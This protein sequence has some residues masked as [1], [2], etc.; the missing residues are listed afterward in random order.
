MDI[1]ALIFDVNGTLIDI[2]TDEGMEQIYRSIGHF[3]AYQGIFMRRWEVRDL[4]FQI[5]KQ[6]LEMSQEIYPEFD[7]VAV[8]RE[9]LIQTG[10]AYT[11]SLPPEKFEQLPLFLAELQR[12]IS[13]RRLVPY[14]EVLDTLAL[15]K[16]RYLLAV[17]TDA[18]SAYAVPELRSA[19]IA[20]YFEPIIVSGDYG[21]RKPDPRLFQAA[22]EE[23]Q[24][25]PDQA[26]FIGN[27]RFRD[28]FGPQQIGMKTILYSPNRDSSNG[29]EPD[30][31]ISR[32][33]ELS[34]ALDFFEVL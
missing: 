24:L 31:I 27:D 29:A 23:L 22:L 25:R 34:Q 18:Q 20:E 16:H 5:K 2:E 30:Y 21:Y 13:R 11:Q 4:Y 26:I 10:G 7:A 14:P 9:V 17:V 33:S 15:L 8:W 6:Q 19:G 12:G 3:L 28:I 1:R 32:H